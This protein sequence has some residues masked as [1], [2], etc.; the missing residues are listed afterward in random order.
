MSKFSDEA[1][2]LDLFLLLESDRAWLVR[3][4]RGTEDWL[5]KSQCEFPHDCKKGDTVS[6]TVPNWLSEEK[7]L[8]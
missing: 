8:E 6:V 1:A 3:D 2:D 7:G 5:P 4:G